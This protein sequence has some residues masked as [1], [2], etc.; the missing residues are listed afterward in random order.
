[1]EKKRDVLMRRCFELQMPWWFSP[2]H[3]D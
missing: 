1:M 3:T 2:K